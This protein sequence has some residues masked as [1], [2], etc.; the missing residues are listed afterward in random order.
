MI[1]LKWMRW[2]SKQSLLPSPREDK[3]QFSTLW[4]F[5]VTEAMVFSEFLPNATNVIVFSFY[6]LC[7]M[8]H[9]FIFVLLRYGQMWYGVP[10]WINPL[11][12]NTMGYT[13]KFTILSY[14]DWNR[15]FI[16]VSLEISGSTLVLYINY[17]CPS[18][19]WTSNDNNLRNVFFMMGRDYLINEED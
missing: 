6:L 11:L 19:L 4:D 10:L 14:F 1:P 12:N 18:K 17:F 8:W 3:L 13:E 9:L 2:R 5:S 7:R 15:F 16:S